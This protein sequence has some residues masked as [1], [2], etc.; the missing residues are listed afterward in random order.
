MPYWIRKVCEHIVKHYKEKIE[1]NGYKAQIVVYDRECCHKYKEELD[2]LL[3]P[4]ATTVVM[5]TNNDKQDR[6]K[7]YR[8]NR[9]EEGK[10]LDQFRDKSNPL[11]MVIVTAKLLTGF[12]PLCQFP[13]RKRRSLYLPNLPPG[14]ALACAPTG[15]LPYGLWR[16]CD[17]TAG[18]AFPYRNAPRF[19]DTL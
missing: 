16:I 8:R 13:R 10:V 11:K 6:Y 1:P 15:W 2:K 12:V 5:D 14:I 18:I 19:S 3:H 4:E 17:N 9:D 7:K